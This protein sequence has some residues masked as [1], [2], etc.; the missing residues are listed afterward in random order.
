[1]KKIKNIVFDQGGVLIHFTRD[2][3][4]RRFIQI[5]L[6]EADE[7][8]GA[9]E[10]KGVF[11]EFENGKADVAKLCSELSRL[12]GKELS[13]EQIRWAW[14]G[15]IVEVPKYKMDYIWQLKDRYHLYLLSNTNPIVQSWAETNQFSAAGRPVTDY[16]EKMYLSYKVGVIKPDRSIFEFMLEDSG[17]HPE[18]TLFVDDSAANIQ[19]GKEFGFH[20][21]HPLN[22]TD[23]RA[24]LDACLNSL[25]ENK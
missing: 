16:F 8:I 20:T 23:W 22:A 6:K 11:L 9:Y 12:A 15:F 19:V 2:E 14:L 5:G 3:A 24:D 7:L 13:Y 25:E 17:I 4:V 21:F 10:Q 1:M 18:E